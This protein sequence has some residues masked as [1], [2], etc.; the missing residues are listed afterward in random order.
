M[1]KDDY[2][3]DETAKWKRD[4]FLLLRRASEA[5]TDN[6]RSHQKAD[7]PSVNWKKNTENYVV[8]KYRKIRKLFT[9]L[10]ILVMENQCKLTKGTKLIS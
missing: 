4:G 6:I 3:G 7:D 9:K 2:E 8:A 5:C 10:L 1:V